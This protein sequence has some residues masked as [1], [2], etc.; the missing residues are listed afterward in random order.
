MERATTRCGKRCQWRRVEANWHAVNA[1]G[2]QLGQS[3][4]ESWLFFRMWC[5]SSFRVHAGVA[6]LCLASS[7]LYASIVRVDCT[8]WV[9]LVL[10]L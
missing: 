2:G 1:M 9:L 6:L 5:S 4:G 10:V 8:C 3:L 7:A